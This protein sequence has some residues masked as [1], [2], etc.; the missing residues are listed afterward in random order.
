MHTGGAQLSF[1]P[2]VVQTF[3]L[4]PQFLSFPSLTLF[5]P[6]EVRE[7]SV[8]PSQYKVCVLGLWVDQEAQGKELVDLA[9]ALESGRWVTHT[10][11]H[12]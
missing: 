3:I 2:N 12:L 10:Y 5:Q 7:V 6:L 9:S 4:Y 8:K 11:F 1:A